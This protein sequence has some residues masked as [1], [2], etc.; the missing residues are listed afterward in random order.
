MKKK[1]K[2]SIEGENMD[3]HYDKLYFLIFL[4]VTQMN[5]GIAHHQISLSTFKLQS[6]SQP[7]QNP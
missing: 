6:K 5:H 2:G 1:Q 4:N 3:L 7:R